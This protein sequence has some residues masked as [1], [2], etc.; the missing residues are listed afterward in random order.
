MEF[1]RTHR[2]TLAV[3]GGLLTAAAVFLWITP[4]EQTLGEGL[5]IVFVHAALIQ[6]GTIGLIVAGL[7]GVVVLLTAHPALEAWLRTI[8]GVAL[9]FYA[10]GVITSMIAAQVNW[11]GVYLQEPRM[12]ASL[13]TLALALIVQVLNY[14]L[15][16]AGADSRIALRIG[17]GLSA[18]LAAYLIWSVATAP[19]V[20]HPSSPV[21]QSSSRAI[22]WSFYGLLAMCLL[23]AGWVVWRMRGR[24]GT[25]Q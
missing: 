1:L 20:L 7:I 24:G 19:L 5:K 8:G 15:D 22:Q 4:A 25:P 23:A 13:N 6:T 3:L 17:G 9:A 21:A 18:A 10:A 12:A 16:H 14:W 11:G 2:L